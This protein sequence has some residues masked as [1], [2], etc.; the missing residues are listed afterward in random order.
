V[1]VEFCFV[2]IWVIYLSAWLFYNDFICPSIN[3]IFLIMDNTLAFSG[4]RWYFKIFPFF[5]RGV[6]F[7]RCL[8][9]IWI[10]FIMF[11]N[12]LFRWHDINS[13][14]FCAPDKSLTFAA[15]YYGYI[16]LQK[17]TAENEIVCKRGEFLSITVFF[18]F[19]MSGYI[20]TLF[21]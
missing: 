12:G 11:V 5:S 21:L 8:S 14:F 20:N 6:S 10:H 17:K 18:F 15:L 4:L 3:Y 1:V 13:L 19:K 16:K 9:Q 7:V 2:F